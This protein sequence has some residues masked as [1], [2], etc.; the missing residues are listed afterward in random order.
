MIDILLFSLFIYLVYSNGSL[1]RKLGKNGIVWGLIT[2]L[3]FMGGNF[4]GSLIVMGFFYKGDWGDIRA[5]IKFLLDNPAKQWL[6]TACALGGGI[7]IRYIL[8]REKPA[9]KKDE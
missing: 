4:I 3:G 9:L 8:E 6:I 2:F 1:A 7:F 5:W